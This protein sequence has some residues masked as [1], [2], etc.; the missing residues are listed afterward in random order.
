M[1]IVKFQNK[2][3]MKQAKNPN[4]FHYYAVFWNRKSKKYNAIRLTHIAKKDSSNYQKAD[5]GL[6][7][8]IRLKKIDKY[9]DNGITNV[10]YVNNAKN[11]KIDIKQGIVIYNSVSSFRS[12]KI[13]SMI[14][15]P[16]KTL[17]VNKTKRVQKKKK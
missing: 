17:I 16:K 5:K 14:S 13:L 3:M 10:N 7:M 2:Y 12:K 9:A 15:N 1:K 6:I 8:P 4:G 11:K